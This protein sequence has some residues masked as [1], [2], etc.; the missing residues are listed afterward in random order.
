MLP[1]QSKPSF[2]CP[3]PFRRFRYI[4]LFLL[5]MTILIYGNSLIF[6]GAFGY[7]S[8]A[9]PASSR[10]LVSLDRPDHGLYALHIV[11]YDFETER[12]E[13]V[14][15]KTLR[16]IRG[17]ALPPGM[18]VPGSTIPVRYL[19]LLPDINGPAAGLLPLAMVLVL[20]GASLVAGSM[21][22]RRKLMDACR[23]LHVTI[24]D[25]ELTPVRHTGRHG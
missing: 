7:T 4:F 10:P 20:I 5:G 22:M 8:D 25:G 18:P 21:A 12:E 24:A 13:R 16:L 19:K 2:V 9:V 14:S 15:G 3:P 11:Q 6:L 1:N 17:T 23:R